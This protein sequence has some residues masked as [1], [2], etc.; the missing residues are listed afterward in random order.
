MSNPNL[1]AILGLLGEDPRKVSLVKELTEKTK[2]GKVRWVKQR[3]AFTANL[4]G[5][6]EVNLVTQ[7]S[8]LGGDS[9]L[10]FTVRDP[11]GTELV[12]VVPPKPAFLL[13]SA[14]AS[15][16]GGEPDLPHAVDDLLAAVSRSAGDDLDRAISTV[17]NL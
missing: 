16:P 3:N 6:L 10:L 2:Q 13:P 17:K 7:P 4:S 9:W 5:T 11:K 15:I 8:L 12:R 14:P 1:A